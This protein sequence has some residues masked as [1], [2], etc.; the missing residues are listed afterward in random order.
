MLNVLN[1]DLS[2]AIILLFSTKEGIL[3]A[4]IMSAPH[5]PLILFLSCLFLSCREFKEIL[6]SH[7]QKSYQTHAGVLSEKLPRAF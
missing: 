7:T 3:S 4:L 5:F 1:V 2:L 6:Y